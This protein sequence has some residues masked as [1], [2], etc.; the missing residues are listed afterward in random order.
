MKIIKL[1]MA[2][3]I[4]MCLFLPLSQCTGISNDTKKSNSENK[5]LNDN[6][7]S[8][9]GN[10]DNKVKVHIIIDSVEDLLN[11]NLDAVPG[12]LAFISPL[13]FSIS[14]RKKAWRIIFL[15]LQTANQ[16]W[17]G[18]ITFVV[19]WTLYDPLWGGYLLTFCVSIYSLITI[20][21]WI[22]LFRGKQLA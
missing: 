7:F 16:I 6:N 17:L 10:S 22:N 20:V 3:G 21:E 5:K 8:V 19:V 11:L 14:V 1:I 18:F 9:E 2:L 12:L 4:F 15:V 13:L